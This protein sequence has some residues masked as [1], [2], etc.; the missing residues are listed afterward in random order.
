MPNHGVVCGYWRL[1]A[2]ERD[3]LGKD[4]RHNIMNAVADE[5]K[6][7]ESKLSPFPSQLTLC[8]WRSIL[9]GGD[10]FHPEWRTLYRCFP[11]LAAGKM[12]CKHSLR[13]D[14]R[15]F[16]IANHPQ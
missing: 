12:S 6:V 7:P 9:G 1:F 4:R 15:S 10:S 5:P 3:H 2:N 8:T 13:D 11:K 16:G 14:V